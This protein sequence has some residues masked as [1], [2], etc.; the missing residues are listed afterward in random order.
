MVAPGSSEMVAEVGQGNGWSL[1]KKFKALVLPSIPED[2]GLFN[3]PGAT[4]ENTRNVSPET[5]NKG[6][7]D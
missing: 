2:K 3:P 7:L 6:S 5:A 1:L 4:K